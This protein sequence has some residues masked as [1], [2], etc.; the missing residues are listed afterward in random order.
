MGHV[1]F[2]KTDE[3]FEVDFVDGINDPDP[4]TRTFDHPVDASKECEKIADE[5]NLL[6]PPQL[7]THD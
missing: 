2:T 3:G 4:S 5:I 1:G 7:I 6:N